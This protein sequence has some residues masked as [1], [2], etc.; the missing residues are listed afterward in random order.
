MVTV[1]DFFCGAG[2]STLGMKLAGF[3][4]RLAVNHTEIAIQ[5]HGYNHPETDHACEDLQEKDSHPGRYPRTTILWASP[6]CTKHS[7][8]AGRKRKGIAQVDMFTGKSG[9]DPEAEKSRV[10]MDWVIRA[11]AFHKYD[12]VIC[13]NVL[14]VTAWHAYHA[15]WASMEALGYFGKTVSLNSQFFGVPQ[16][17]DRWYAVFT[18]KGMKIPD[19]DFQP[20]AYCEKCERVVEAYLAWKRDV[21]EKKYKPWGRYGKS[22]QYWYKCP[23]CKSIVHP[24]TL[25]AAQVIDWTNLG[26][27]IGQREEPLVENTLKRIRKGLLKFI[28]SPA[29]FIAPIRGTAVP[30]SV[31]SPLTVVTTAQQHALIVPQ[32]KANPTSVE[33]PLSTITGSQQHA[34]IVS[35]YSRDTATSSITRPLPVVPT[36]NRHYVLRTDM[37]PFLSVYNNG[38]GQPTSVNQPMWTIPTKDRHALIVPPAKVSKRE[39]EE[40]LMASHY[41]LL[42]PEELKLAMSFPESYTILGAK[43]QQVKQIGNAVCPHVA[44]WIGQRVLEAYAAS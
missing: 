34:L 35:Y 14:E 16:S 5:T 7:Q 36:E 30:F 38:D 24:P 27:P 39:L 11:T 41:R 37:T 9:I 17:R 42:E 29:E 43:Y 23:S 19:L 28:K 6:E 4:V 2:G 18:K 8:A 26:E 22:G 15:W 44:Q 13:E 33:E 25:P 1:T 10:T 31:N 32:R 40:T 12:Y 20:H 21:N 3:D